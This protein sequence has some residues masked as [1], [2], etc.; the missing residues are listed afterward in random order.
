[1]KYV[2]GGG[3]S[4]SP[5]ASDGYYITSSRMYQEKKRAAGAELAGEEKSFLKKSIFTIDTGE[6][7]WYN[8]CV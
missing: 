8:P 2:N 3:I 1:M 5:Q 4:A 7:T 6:M